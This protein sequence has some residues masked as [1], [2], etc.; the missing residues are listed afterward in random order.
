VRVLIFGGRGYARARHL[1]AVLDALDAEHKITLVVHGDAP[2]AD[3]LADRWAE[4][5]GIDRVKFP[6]NW[7]GRGK[8]GGPYRNGLMIRTMK[9]E[10]GVGFPGGVGTAG[11]AKLLRAAGIPVHHVPE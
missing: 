6:A 7:I 2:G 3:T 5:R 10:M 9:P 8:P 1:N 11:M 4:A